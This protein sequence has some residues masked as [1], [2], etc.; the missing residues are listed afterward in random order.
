MMAIELAIEA[1]VITLVVMFGL[2]WFINQA[3]QRRK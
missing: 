2:L 1:T 3:K